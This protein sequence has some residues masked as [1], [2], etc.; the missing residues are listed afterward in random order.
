MHTFLSYHL[1]Y[2]YHA[3]SILWKNKC[4]CIHSCWAFLTHCGE[5]ISIYSPF[6]VI[7]VSRT[8]LQW[9]A[10]E[11]YREGFIPRS[12]TK[13]SYRGC[14]SRFHTMVSYHGFILRFHTKV[15]YHDDNHGSKKPWYFNSFCTKLFVEF[16]FWNVFLKAL[17]FSCRTK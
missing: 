15:S 5:S 1:I 8:M 7:R 14:I 10:G 13:L 11:S 2:K 12:H 9:W 16:Q 6:I 4:P 17:L 3:C